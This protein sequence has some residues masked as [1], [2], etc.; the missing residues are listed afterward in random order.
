MNRSGNKAQLDVLQWIADG[1]D[2]E[3]LV[4]PTFKTTAIALS[5]RGLATVDRRRGKWAA[6]LTERGAYYL[7]NG[8]YLV[9][10]VG[11]QREP[12][13]STPPAASPVP[14]GPSPE[15]K[16]KRAPKRRLRSD[17]ATARNETIPMPSQV[18]APHA[19]IREL[20]DHKSRLAV[21]S[22][23]RQ[24]ALLL[25]H[26]IVQESLRRGWTVTPVL[27]ELRSYS[28][29]RTKPRVWPSDDLF[30]VDAGHQ[31]VP[32]RLR[33]KQRQVPHQPTKDELERKERYGYEPYRRTDLVATDRMRLQ[34]GESSAPL[35]L[36]D[37]A[38][39]RIEDKLLRAI[40]KIEA[41]SE[42][43]LRLEEQWRQRAIAEAEERARAEAL[44]QRAAQYGAWASTLE[45][46]QAAAAQHQGLTE[47]V[48]R[49]RAALPRLRQ[50]PHYERL[51]AYADWAEQHVID[52]DPFQVIQLPNGDRPDMTHAEWSAWKARHPQWQY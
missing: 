20:V 48:D 15:A 10:A 11:P 37:T 38:A 13:G 42:E 14:A 19:A 33:M 4:T 44:R 51:K 35:V 29:D 7:A 6:T 46:L 16:K 49:L 40:E 23:Q 52:S 39:T 47:T 5:N 1:C 17:S 12:A 26:A 9:E 45:S 43:R 30:R 18:R 25:L 34:V 31:V 2:M 50:S 36:E 32:I 27:S 8:T 28:W 22:D 21:P 24:R 3:H 41:L